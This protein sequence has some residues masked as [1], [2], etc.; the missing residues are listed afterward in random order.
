VG[1]RGSPRRRRRRAARRG[2]RLG[3]AR[4]ATTE[5][6][7]RFT[8]A[9]VIT[10]V[11]ITGLDSTMLNVA[12]PTII[13]DLDSDL[14]AVQWVVT[15][16][17][18]MFATLLI[19]G[20]RLGDLYGR[21]R[22]FVIG[23]A[24]FGVGSLIA[25]LSP[26]VAWLITGE[27]VIEGIGA[28]LMLPSSLAILTTAFEGRARTRAFAA[29]G[30]FGGLSAALGPLLGG[31]LTSYASWRVGFAIN[32]V[33]APLAM[34]GSL[35]F[36]P[37]G[38]SGAEHRRLDVTG[39]AMIA[40][41][42]FAL[43]F[44]LSQGSRYG[45]FRPLERFSLAG[46]SPWP[47][48]WPVSL[49]PCLLVL[50]ALILAGFV[51]VERSKERRGRGP[52]FEVGQLRLARFRYGLLTTMVMSIAAFSSILVLPLYLQQ[53]RLLSPAD[54]G[55]WAL[56]AGVCTFIGSRLAIPAV[57]RAGVT[58]VVRL[59]LAIQAVG[60]LYLAAMIGPGFTFL[61]VLIGTACTGLGGGLTFSQLT[62]VVLHDV[63][64]EHSGMASGANTTARQVG[65][66]I[67]VATAGGLFS[68]LAER[69]LRS[70]LRAAALPA[71]LKAQ[72]LG[73]VGGAAGRVS[74]PPGTSS[75]DARV[76]VHTVQDA[77]G[78][79]A[80]FPLLLAAA[81]VLGGLGVSMS[82]P[83]LGPE[84]GDEPPPASAAAAA[85]AG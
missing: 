39:A 4:I 57:G 12:L 33:A 59:G 8:L 85:E 81:C 45:W 61:D 79:A 22:I 50:A 10:A 2:A 55:W 31:L 37:E 19:V 77:L 54:N 7:Q 17:S 80:R 56:P 76:V 5:Q 29:W 64:P 16:Y 30:A 36:I 51:A 48:T 78:D 15:G 42:M 60:L 3:A 18:L 49:V 72:L 34:V 24:L 1:H 67:G 65:F 70:G 68:A 69:H 63:A 28:S 58:T 27:A 32:V 21:R 44:A 38:R 73:R 71:D 47:E 84:R 23:N 66:A 9:I 25:A 52:L 14:D 20:G 11:L 35:A 6:H 43:V 40:A 41:G 74:A 13:R 75:G 62:S 46:T 82:I 83:R 53:G 26:S